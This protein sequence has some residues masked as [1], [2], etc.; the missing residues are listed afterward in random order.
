MSLENTLTDA[1]LTYSAFNLQRRALIDSRDGLKHS[2]RQILH[3]QKR[4][5]LDYKHPFKK[6]LKSVSAATS[7]SYVHGDNSAYSTL[8]RMGRPLVQR[9]FFEEISGNYG[10][11]IKNDDFSSSRYVEMRMSELGSLLFNC[12]D[13]QT[14]QKEDWAPTYDDENVYPLVLPSLGFYNLCNGSLGIGSTLIASIPQFNLKEMNNELIKLINDRSYNPSLTPDFSSGSVLLNPNSTL[15]SLQNGEGRSAI[16]RSHIKRNIAEHWLEITDLPYGVFTEEVCKQLTKAFETNEAPFTDFK[17]LTKD[18]VRIR[19]YSTDLDKLEQWL[20]K[21]TSCQKHFSIKLIMLDN[22]KVPKLFTL[23]EALLSHIDH[24]KLVYRRSLKYQLKQLVYREEIIQ[25]LLKAYSII[26]KVISTI[27]SSTGR[28]DSIN[29]LVSLFQFTIPQAEAIVDLRLHRLSSIDI[30]KLN[31]E[32]EANKLSQ[33]KLQHLLQTKIDFNKQLCRFYE[34]VSNKFG[35]ARRTEIYTG[36]EYET[37]SEGSHPTSE[38]S[39]K[40]NNGEGYE[41]ISIEESDN[42]YIVANSEDDIVIITNTL[43][44][45]NRYGS[46]LMFGE[47]DWKDE[48]NLKDNEKVILVAFAETLKQYKSAI[49]FDKQNNMF[50]MHIS[51]ITTSRSPRGK[52]LKGTKPGL[53]IQTVLFK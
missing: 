31:E 11:P 14:I 25:G 37:A 45:F 23:K 53:N 32:L 36:I 2:A 38:F 48:L 24:A 21:N 47:H 30:K 52:R 40:W 3:A 28:Q 46:E 50:D 29:Q 35:D 1:F 49:F 18:K 8:I 42:S 39:I 12:I 34:E 20:Y 22:G 41:L 15:L 27:K 26:D 13:E 43:R 5:K 17:D 4:D 16:L 19:I 6:A 10:T 7:F 33:G 9:Y 51:F 44:K